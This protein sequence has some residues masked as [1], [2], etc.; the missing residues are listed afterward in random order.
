MTAH[1]ERRATPIADTQ[2]QVRAARREQE[3]TA[4]QGGAFDENRLDRRKSQRSADRSAHRGDGDKVSR[5]KNGGE[6]PIGLHAGSGSRL[7]N[8]EEQI[9][10]PAPVELRIG[11]QH[12]A[13]AH[14]A[15]RHRLDVVRNDE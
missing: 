12:D 11:G 5:W 14:H 7:E 8:A 13:V 15:E 9:V 10:Y 2:Q 6:H 1:C 4:C 3:H